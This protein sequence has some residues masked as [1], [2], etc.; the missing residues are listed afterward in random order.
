MS[1][2]DFFIFCQEMD[3]FQ[4]ERDADGT[5]LIMELAGSETGSFN[6][7]VTTELNIWNRQE[8]NGKTFD[9]SSG[10]T[11][12]NKAVRSPDTA[13]IAIE[14]WKALPKEDRESFAHISPDFVIEIRSKTDSLS[15][16]QAKMVE[17][18]ENGV[19]L[20][21][22]IDLITENVWIYRADGTID[23]IESFDQILSGEDVLK[24]FE[25]RLAD[26]WE[27]EN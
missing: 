15:R 11:L 21:W 10:F 12:P 25:L 14:R 22:L 26:I 16:L 17:Y 27:K 24:G 4:I 1:E 13:W 20:G 3:A 18:R 9:S 6:S 19:K 5:I 7:E 23:K 2:E 8:K